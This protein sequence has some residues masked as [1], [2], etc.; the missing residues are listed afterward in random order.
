VPG[1]EFKP[2][3]CQK[4]KR[5][6]GR[7]ERVREK[8]NRRERKKESNTDES[9]PRAI[10]LSFSFCSSAMHIVPVEC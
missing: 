2:H 4:I 7:K 6:G 8:E 3:Y 9:E 10:D 5:V 1:S